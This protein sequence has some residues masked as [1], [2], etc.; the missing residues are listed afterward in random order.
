MHIY[1]K[2]LD[3]SMDSF[4]TVWACVVYISHSFGFIIQMTSSTI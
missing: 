1:F 2:R 4:G 3:H